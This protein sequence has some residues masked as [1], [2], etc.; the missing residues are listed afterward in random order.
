M[1]TARR[2]RATAPR[3]RER[4]RH[5]DQQ[6]VRL[7]GSTF[8]A[9]VATVSAAFHVQSRLAQTISNERPN[10]TIPLGRF[11]LCWRDAHKRFDSLSM[12]LRVAP[13]GHCCSGTAAT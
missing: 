9:K 13:L 6:K 8:S 3:E 2:T 11:A 4:T 10:V 5:R 12:I 7:H 1:G